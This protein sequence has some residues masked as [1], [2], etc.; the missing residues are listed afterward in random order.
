MTLWGEEGGGLFENT[1][2]SLKQWIH[3]KVELFWE[4]NLD[5]KYKLLQK[6]KVV[7]IVNLNFD[8]YKSWTHI[9]RISYNPKL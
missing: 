8:T 6:N 9:I 4:P 2:W 7:F 5:L 3:L 1:P